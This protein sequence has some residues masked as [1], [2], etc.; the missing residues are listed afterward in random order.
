MPPLGPVFK[1]GWMIRTVERSRRNYGRSALSQGRKS[2]IHVRFCVSVRISTDR[3][4]M[5]DSA[6]YV[7]WLT[8]AAFAAGKG[9]P[10]VG[11]PVLQGTAGCVRR[12]AGAC[13]RRVVLSAPWMTSRWIRRS[14]VWALRSV[15]RFRRASPVCG[16][17]VAWRRQVWVLDSSCS[18]LSPG[19]CE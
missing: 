7:A 2:Q 5:F 19:D 15:L 13:C 14:R 4:W 18:G 6:D 8:P 3:Y 16:S 12:S 10:A 11:R 9:G 1:R 17:R